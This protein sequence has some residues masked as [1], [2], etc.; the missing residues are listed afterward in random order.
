M[1][2][3]ELFGRYATGIDKPEDYIKWAEEQLLAGSN[4]VNMAILAGLD[5]EKPIDTQEVR[6]YFSRCMRELCIEWPDQKSAHRR[7]SEVLCRKILDDELNPQ[8]GLST[9][10][11]LYRS[12]GYSELY[13]LWDELEEDISLMETGYGPIFNV[14]VHKDNVDEYIKKVA[15]QYLTLL[16][17][18]LPSNFPRLAY[19]SQCGHIAEPINKR[20]DK[21]WLPEK[22]YRLLYRK[23][24]TYMMVCGSCR[25]VGLV[26]MRAYE[27]R[28]KYLCTV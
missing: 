10:A 8:V 22:I 18:N 6:E 11:Q 4:S 19:C 25:S 27:G 1:N 21:P 23:G 26:S 5:V 14:G 7:Y 13:A 3:E 17:M 28:E 9:L 2:V 20:V 24:P 12:S 15:T 16:A